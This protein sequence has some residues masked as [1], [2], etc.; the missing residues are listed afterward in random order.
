MKRNEEE[1]KKEYGN[2]EIEEDK[3]GDKPREEETPR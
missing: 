3:Q 2:Q 1:R